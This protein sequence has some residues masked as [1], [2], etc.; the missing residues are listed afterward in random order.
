[1]WPAEAPYHILQ[2]AS[3]RKAQ[4]AMSRAASREQTFQRRLYAALRY[5]FPA[6]NGEV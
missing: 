2:Q 5:P 6:T 1:M 4:Q 3:L